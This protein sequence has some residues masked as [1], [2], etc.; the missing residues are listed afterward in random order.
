MPLPR[1]ATGTAKGA[2]RGCSRFARRTQTRFPLLAGGTLRRGL[3]SAVCPN[4]VA[5][6]SYSRTITTGGTAIWATGSSAR[7]GGGW[8]CGWSRTA[9][10]R[11]LGRLAHCPSRLTTRWR[12]P[13]RSN[14]PYRRCVPSLRPRCCYFPKG[15][16]TATQSGCC[17]SNGR[18]TGWRAARHRQRCC[19]WRFTL[20]RATT[21]TRARI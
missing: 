21:S 18:C 3:E 5:P 12:A 15:R 11:R 20:S 2:T 14:A 10:S 6:L 17:R 16:C 9:A 13:A 1:F 7:G 8:W 19:R 4:S